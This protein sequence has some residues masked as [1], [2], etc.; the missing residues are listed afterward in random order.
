MIKRGRADTRFGQ[1][2]MS[3]TIAL[4]HKFYN[5]IKRLTDGKSPMF[6]T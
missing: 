3:S 1:I 2:N 4:S 6:G 5:H